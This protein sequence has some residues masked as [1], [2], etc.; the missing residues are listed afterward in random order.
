MADKRTGA[1][2]G[3]GSTWTTDAVLQVASLRQA[4]TLY[5]APRGWQSKAGPVAMADKRT[6]ADR[7]RGSTWT[8]DA[9]LQVASLRQAT[10]LYSAPRGWQSKA[11]PCTARIDSALW[12]PNA[13]LGVFP[14]L[15]VTMVNA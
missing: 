11:G 13:S 5:S 6:G 4:T 1:D 3:R 14:P 2:R 7:G 12:L 10:T 15:L 8:T 9:V